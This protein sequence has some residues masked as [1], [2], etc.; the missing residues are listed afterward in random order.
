MFQNRVQQAKVRCEPWSV[1]VL[2]RRVRSW[3]W[4]IVIC[5]MKVWMKLSNKV[6]WMFVR[7]WDIDRQKVSSRFCDVQ[8]IGHTTHW[9][10]VCI[11]GFC[12]GN[13]GH[14]N[15]SSVYG[16]TKHKFQGPRGV[17]EKEGCRGIATIFWT[18]NLHTAHG[19]FETGVVGISKNFWKVH[20]ASFV[21]L[22]LEGRII[23]T[24]LG[25]ANFLCHL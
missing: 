3:L 17:S 2:K 1:P 19:A 24:S 10:V 9:Y 8:F 6:K 25:V 11:G 16:W 7:F 22:Q 20:T 4:Q 18:C 13:W 5:L 23:S 12:H 15:D 21:I 14:S